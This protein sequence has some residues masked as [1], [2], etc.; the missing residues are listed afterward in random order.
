MG[1]FLSNAGATWVKSKT[2]IE[3]EGAFAGSGSDAHIA[4]VIGTRMG[5]ALKDVAAPTM[6]TSIKTITMTALLMAPL[7]FIDRSQPY[8]MTC[9]AKRWASPGLSTLPCY[10]WTKAYWSPLPL[11]F[12]ALIILLFYGEFRARFAVNARHAHA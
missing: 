3:A 9:L 5:S 8:F 4:S 12:L 1:Y 7:I 11:F 6:V 10:D 2:S